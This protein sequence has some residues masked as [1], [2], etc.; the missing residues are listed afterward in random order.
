MP[1]LLYF[2]LS[3]QALA[4][5]VFQIQVED[6]KQSPDQ[7]LGQNPYSNSGASNGQSFKSKPGIK[8]Y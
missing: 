8:F 7:N 5:I 6:L 2:K 4:Q 3:I 1:L